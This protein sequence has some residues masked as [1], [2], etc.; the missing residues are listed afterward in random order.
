[1]TQNDLY[2]VQPTFENEIV[3]LRPITDE[4]IPALLRCYSDV[5]AVPLFNSD[6]CNGDDFHYTTPEQMEKAVAFW[7]QSYLDR[8]FIRWAAVDQSLTE[9][10]GT[11]EMFHRIADDADNH[12][13]LL[14][15]DLQSRFET[16]AFIHA[17]LSLCLR[18]FFEGFEVERIITK[19]PPQ[20][21]ERITALEAAGFVP[22]SR[23]LGSYPFYYERIR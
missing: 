1:M 18:H 11:V 16:R 22:M 6:N 2:T 8:A 7:R 19:A 21:R 14:R 13:G 23:T 20:A 9:V 10:V 5:H 4:D 12:V 17:L 15:V 3:L